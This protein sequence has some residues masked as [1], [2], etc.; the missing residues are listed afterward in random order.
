MQLSACIH[1]W[2]GANCS[3][4]GSKSDGGKGAAGCFQ[5]R[6][7]IP[8]LHTK[9]LHAS[10]MRSAMLSGAGASAPAVTTLPNPRTC[11]SA[12]APACSSNRTCLVRASALYL[13]IDFGTSGARAT[14]IDGVFLCVCWFTPFTTP[15]PLYC[16]HSPPARAAADDGNTAADCKQLYQPSAAADWAAAWQQVLFELI[17]AL[18]ASVTSQVQA[19]AFDGTSSTALLVDG[20]TGRVLCAPKLYDEAQWPAAVAAAKVRSAAKVG[21][22]GVWRPPELTPA[23]THTGQQKL[24][25]VGTT[26]MCLCVQAIAPASHTA[27]ASTSTLCKV[28]TWHLAHAWQDAAA[29]GAQPCLMHQADWLAYLLHGVCFSMERLQRL[30]LRDAANCRRS[31]RTTVP[32]LRCVCCSVGSLCCIADVCGFAPSLLVQVSVM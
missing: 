8:H 5:S 16:S 28:L 13:G 30:P 11:T 12:A 2:T 15:H 14:V 6:Y 1:R 18:P 20:A 31:S 27:T 4:P 22:A 29:A 17:A 26:R 23:V 9:S 24:M 7:S 32:A 3:Q 25:P 19:V 21:T 10:D